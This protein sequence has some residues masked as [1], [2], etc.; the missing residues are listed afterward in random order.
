MGIYASLGIPEVWR[1]ANH[2]LRVYL[3][4]QVRQYLEADRSPTFPTIPVSEL[5]RFSDLGVAEGDLSMA[6]AFRAWVRERLA[7]P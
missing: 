3:L 2:A 5:V 4:N 1:Y 6:R 7:Q